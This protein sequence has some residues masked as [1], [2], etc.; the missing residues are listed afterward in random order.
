[1]L[2]GRGLRKAAAPQLRPEMTVLR[3]ARA[4][5][6]RS[7]HSPL[8][9]R[10]YWSRLRGL[11]SQPSNYEPGAAADRAELPNPKEL[12]AGH[13]PSANLTPEFV[14]Y[15]TRQG[16]ANRQKVS[17]RRPR[18]LP[19]QLRAASRNV[20]SRIFIIFRVP[21]ATRTRLILLPPRGT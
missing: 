20:L 1:M 4:R 7:R 10:F 3:L 2:P 19:Y 11:N 13:R 21:T 5:R 14:V 12:L 6:R 15:H 18:L 8:D 17:Y 16:T 9:Q